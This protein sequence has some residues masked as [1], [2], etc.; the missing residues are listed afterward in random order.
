[1]I[2]TSFMCDI[3][4]E[5]R[6]FDR[7]SLDQAYPKFPLSLTGPSLIQYKIRVMDQLGR[8]PVLKSPYLVTPIYT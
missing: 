2:S 1:M 3:A 6:Y 7:L 5:I 8:I 4:V